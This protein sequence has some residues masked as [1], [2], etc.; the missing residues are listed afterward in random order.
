MNKSVESML[1]MFFVTL[2]YALRAQRNEVACKEATKFDGRSGKGAFPM[3]A[4]SQGLDCGG[5]SEGDL[6][7]RVQCGAGAGRAS[8]MGVPD[9][10]GEMTER[11]SCPKTVVRLS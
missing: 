1:P 2:S 5:L 8:A 3:G 4:G 9:A 7:R 10:S 6:Q 11:L